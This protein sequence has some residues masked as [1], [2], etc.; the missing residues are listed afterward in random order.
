MMSYSTLKLT[1]EA[2]SAALVLPLVFV[3]GNPDPG[4]VLGTPDEKDVEALEE[5]AFGLF[6]FLYPWTG[7]A[8]EYETPGTAG[9]GDEAANGGS[10]KFRGT[11]GDGD[12]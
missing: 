2:L 1:K 11:P 3:L 9:I 12:G 4:T 7:A 8:T 5:L 6:P 10:E